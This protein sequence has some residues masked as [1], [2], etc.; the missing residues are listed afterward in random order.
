MGAL[1]LLIGCQARESSERPAS[2]QPRAP[3]V[4]VDAG[5]PHRDGEHCGSEPISTTQDAASAWY[6]ERFDIQD[7][8][9]VPLASILE[10]PSSFHQRRVIVA[11]HVKRACS[12]RGCWME[13]APLGRTEEP[14]CRVTFKDYGFL[15]PTDSAGSEA[16]LLGTVQVTAIPRAA[17]EHYESEGGTFPNKKADGTALEVRIVASGVELTR[18]S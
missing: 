8:E 16:R 18:K 15:V 5:C 9:L 13:L 3:S 17:V 1:L 11:G 10:Q 4:V 2:A 12:R 6:G 14:G 7:A